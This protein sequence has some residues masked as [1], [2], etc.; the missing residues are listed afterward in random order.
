MI[1]LPPLAPAPSQ[2]AAAI[3]FVYWAFSFCL[4]GSLISLAAGLM[5]IS[6]TGAQLNFI[7]YLLNLAAAVFIFREFLQENWKAAADRIFPT[8][9]YAVL[10]YLGSQVFLNL[11]TRVI[12]VLRPDFGNVNDQSIQAMLAQSPGIMV[13]G[14]VVLAPVAEEV[15]YRGIFF[16]KLFDVKPWLG[17]GVS[18]LVFAA[19]HTVGY[20]G[21]AEPGLLVLGC[22]Q[23]LPAGYCLCWCY[24]QT[25]NILSP[26]LMHIIFNASSILSLVR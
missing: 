8:I 20:I 14:A 21:T 19:I 1:K 9:Y 25:G 15:F 7:Y 12:L 24:R 26:I 6:L 10:A 18:M 22:L 16:R 2:K 5:G 4:L 13:L 11:V 3:G 23:Y 17:Y